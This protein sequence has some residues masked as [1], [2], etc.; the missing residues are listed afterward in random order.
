MQIYKKGGIAPTRPTRQLMVITYG[1]VYH[2]AKS[3]CL[4]INWLQYF[5]IKICLNKIFIVSLQ[6]RDRLE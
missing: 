5:Q 3:D 2:Q 4:S 1:I 6:S